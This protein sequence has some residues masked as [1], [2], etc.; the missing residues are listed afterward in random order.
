MK[1]TDLAKEF[2]LDPKDFIL[3]LGEAGFKISPRAK[4][5]SEDQVKEIRVRWGEKEASLTE[6]R[7]G[8]M[9][10]KRVKGS[11][12]RRRKVQGGEEEQ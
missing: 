3:R 11:V 1:I 10:E 8:D 12:I 9:L 2:Q 5:L 7:K 6:T 4:T